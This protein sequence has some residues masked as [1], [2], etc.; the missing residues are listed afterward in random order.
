MDKLGI[1]D[2]FE[3]IQTFSASPS[4]NT[5][6]NREILKS[7][8]DQ[9]L[10]DLIELS[11]HKNVQAHEAVAYHLR[12]GGERI[13]A[14]IGFETARTLRNSNADSL[15][16]GCVAEALHNASL[17]HDDIQDKSQSRRG[18]ESIWAHFGEDI[19]IC[20]GDLLISASYAALADLELQGTDSTQRLR[21]LLACVHKNILLVING[22]SGDIMAKTRDIDD[23]MLYCDIA[24]NKS[25]PLISLPLELALIHNGLDDHLNKASYAASQFALAYQIADDI[26]D[27]KQDAWEVEEALNIILVFK[28]MGYSEQEAIRETRSFA[29]QLLK[30]ARAAAIELPCESGMPICKQIER[31]AKFIKTEP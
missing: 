30:E 15:A 21:N 22:Q 26:S 23:I 4:F 20:A 12:S 25:G 13:R 24:R 11:H 1:N 6:E 10:F 16:L 7:F 5:R 28:R 3:N 14:C 17:I 8:I 31:L 9:F 29:A 19:A 18:R 27:F 2:A